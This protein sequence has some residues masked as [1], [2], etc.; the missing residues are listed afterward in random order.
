MRNQRTPVRSLVTSQGTCIA[1]DDG[2]IVWET[3]Q[4]RKT[5]RLHCV[6]TVILG[7]QNDDGHVER[8]FVGDGKGQLHIL[9]V[10]NLALEKTVPVGNTALRAMCSDSEESLALLIADADG[11]IWHYDGRSETQLLFET[12]RSISSIRSEPN[13]IRIQSGWE[14]CTFERDGHLQKSHDAST[15]FGENVMLRRLRERKKLEE[16]REQAESQV[17]L[18]AGF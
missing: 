10:P 13:S 11:K 2:M 8:M 7:M 15:S 6:A 9:T 12:N 16:Q 14:Q 1:M 3:K 17:R 4:N 18:M 5:L